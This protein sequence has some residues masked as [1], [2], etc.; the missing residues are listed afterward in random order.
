[1]FY[2]FED[3]ISLHASTSVIK[4]ILVQLKQCESGQPNII[5]VKQ[6]SLLVS[7]VF[8]RV[9]ITEKGAK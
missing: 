9:L 5:L 7:M 4:F 2:L 3:S 8:L 6:A 1:M